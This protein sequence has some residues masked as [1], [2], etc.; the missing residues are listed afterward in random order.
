MRL[1]L[2]SLLV[3]TSSSLAQ[4]P[5]ATVRGRV[6][7][8]SGAPIVGARV[9]LLGTPRSTY[10]NENGEYALAGLEPRAY[11]LRAQRLGFTLPPVDSIVLSA[12]QTLA[13]D[14]T[15]EAIP[16]RLSQVVVSPGSYSL[17]DPRTSQQV[18]TRDELLTR[19][20]LAED[21][22]R[23]LNR[24]PGMS[25]SDYSAKLRVRNGLTDEVLVTLDGLELVEPFHLK[26]LDAALSMLDVEVIGNVELKT[27]GFGAQYG[28]RTTGVI[29]MTSASPDAD[30]A[31]NSL[32]LSLSNV[33]AKTEGKFS[34]G[35]GSWLASARR[36]YL[37][38]LLKLIGEDEGPDPTYYDLFGKVQ[39]QIGTRHLL[40][41]HGLVSGD[42]LEFTDDGGESFAM[43]RYDNNYAWGTLKSQLTDA[44]SVTTL[45]SW[46]HL[47]WLRDGRIVDQL[48]RQGAPCVF[49]EGARVND[50]RALD[51]VGL[52][53]DWTW[54]ASARLSVLAGG[55]LR[56]ERSRLEYSSI[57]RDW[58]YPQSGPVVLDSTPIA[59]SLEPEGN[60]ISGYTALRARPITR[61]VTEIGVRADRHEWTGQTTIGPRASAA[62]DL[63]PKTTLRAAWGIYP[64]AHAIHDLSVVDGDTVFARAERAEQRVVGIEQELGRGWR[65]RTEAFDRIIRDPRARWI[66]ADGD[67][68]ILP[69]VESD[70]VQLS[71]SDARV[72]GIEWLA[73]Y[74]RGGGVRASGS[75]VLSKG[76]QTQ[77][78]IVTLRPFDERHAIAL[79]LAARSRRGWT[80]AFAFTLHSGWPLIPPAYRVDT[81]SQGPPTLVAVSRIPSEPL[82]TDTRD[83]YH[84]FDVR[85]SKGFDRGRHRISVYVEVF[86]LLNHLNHA[87]NSYNIGFLQ[88]GT[89]RVTPEKEHSLQRLPSLGVRWEF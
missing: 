48:C 43:T 15:L 1:I 73:T 37:D 42:R 61:L 35:R 3:A 9:A 75:Y 82:F 46:S 44:L 50:D 7:D 65:L 63:T 40:S 72:R 56:A 87:G 30:R 77:D 19:P 53:Q 14:V 10:S 28:N 17:L 16:V 32:G 74:D 78:G 89:L 29:E 38:I 70:R 59:A 20:Q 54:D 83:T 45:A 34:G 11:Q 52:K 25:G 71:P 6:M 80:W 2:V 18:L 12:G 67:L 58:G 81:L 88:N 21:L 33:R 84:R 69:E 62:L 57:R 66:N 85:M 5:V 22:F 49:E 36:G 24:L 23:S 13:H 86:N 68:Q 79:D 27:G 55:E 41:I 31:R 26:D 39:R 60:R 64:Q 76:T 4:S 51:V 8:R 47:T